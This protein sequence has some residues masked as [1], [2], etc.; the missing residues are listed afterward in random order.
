MS[1]QG[2]VPARLSAQPLPAD[3]E[4]A[5]SRSGASPQALSPHHP[6]A[7][8]PSPQPALPWA[9]TPPIPSGKGRSMRPAP[10]LLGPSESWR[11]RRRGPRCQGDARLA[12]VISLNQERL[13]RTSLT[14]YCESVFPRKSFSTSSFTSIKTCY[15]GYLRGREC[16][17]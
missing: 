5:W 6:P 9:R 16:K 13:P 12:V 1:A 10:P 3:A 8:A 4:R 11:T 14:T 15:I 17:G 7:Q 2:Q